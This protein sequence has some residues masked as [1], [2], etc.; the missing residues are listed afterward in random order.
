[1]RRSRQGWDN[2]LE[3]GLL[4]EPGMV[5]MVMMM[6][7]VV[8]M[9]HNHYLRLRRI[10]CCEAEDENQSEQNLFH[11]SSIRRPIFEY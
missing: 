9:N 6:M 11:T 1:M 4:S 3:N 10:R 7:V 5:V 8:G 2:E